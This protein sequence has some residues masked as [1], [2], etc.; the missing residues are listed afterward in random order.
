LEP[1]RGGTKGMKMKNEIKT[2]EISMV[3]PYCGDVKRTWHGPASAVFPGV[4]SLKDGSACDNLACQAKEN[5]LIW[6]SNDVLAAELRDN[7]EKSRS[8]A[9]SARRAR[10]R[11]YRIKCN[12]KK[13]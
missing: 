3:C 6:A 9:Q 12:T 10:E 11:F 13:Y 8:S 7:A 1:Q 4:T 2:I 5:R